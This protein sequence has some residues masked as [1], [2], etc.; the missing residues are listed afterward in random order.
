MSP[1]L[2]ILLI[3][4]I[5]FFYVVV[6]VALDVYRRVRGPRTVLCPETGA[7]EEIEIDAW[8]AAATAVPGPPRLRVV[9][10]T[11]WPARAGCREGCLSGPSKL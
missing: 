5:G 7:P 10:C 2:L 3:A 4:A 8:H 11:E 6:P 9:A 1:K